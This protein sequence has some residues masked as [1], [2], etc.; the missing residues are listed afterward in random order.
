MVYRYRQWLGAVV[1]CVL[2]TGLPSAAFPVAQAQ[3]L[4]A[5]QPYGQAVLD[6]L[7]AP[8]ALYPDP[9]LTQVLVAATY[10]LEVIQAE[11]FIKANPNRQGN[12]LAHMVKDKPW[13]TSVKALAEFPSVLTMMHDNL[14]WTQQLGDAFLAQQVEVMDTVQSLRQKAQAQGSLQNTAQQNVVQQGSAIVIQPANPQ[15]VHVPYYNP[16]VVYGAW[17]WPAYPPLFWQPPPLYRPPSFGQ[18]VAAGIAFGAGV[19]IIHSIFDNMHPNWGHHHFAYRNRPHNNINFISIN[20]HPAWQHNPLHR[21]GVAYQNPNTHQQLGYHP[22]DTD[23]HRPVIRPYDRQPPGFNRPDP[24]RPEG[25]RPSP[26]PPHYR[27][28]GGQVQPEAGYT[29]PQHAQQS[30]PAFS[31][32]EPS[33]HPAKWKGG[34]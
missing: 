18:V 3:T 32:H 7:L 23:H 17:D 9:L 22:A 30:R 11:Q 31:R 8:I 5:Q 21:R 29:R 16:N 15:V 2:W 27:P 26:S 34:L 6:Q 13:D 19:A 25:Q 20:G 4:S 1:A 10:P 12:S 24:A 33:R 14:E 28:A